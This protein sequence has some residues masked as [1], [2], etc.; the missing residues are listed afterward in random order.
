MTRTIPPSRHL[1]PTL[2]PE[3][4]VVAVALTSGV[5]VQEIRGHGRMPSVLAARWAAAY[6]LRRWTDQSW[7]QIAAAIRPQGSSHTQAIAMPDM[8]MQARGNERVSQSRRD[9]L[10]LVRAVSVVLRDV[11]RD[12]RALWVKR[13]G[14]QTRQV[15]VQRRNAW[16]NEPRSPVWQR[17]KGGA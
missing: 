12:E 2:S 8:V 4:I 7:P 17:V 13:H 11:A 6:L 5:S 1:T 14:E 15:A 16:R 9:A 10:A 3:A